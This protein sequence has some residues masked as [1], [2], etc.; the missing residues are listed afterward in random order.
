MYLNSAGSK[1]NSPG[2]PEGLREARDTQRRCRGRCAVWY[3][4][5]IY[6]RPPGDALARRT[7]AVVLSGPCFEIQ[8]YTATRMTQKRSHIC[9]Q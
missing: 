3:C 4:V 9:E 7:S 2:E 1:T 5:L 6:T 8:T